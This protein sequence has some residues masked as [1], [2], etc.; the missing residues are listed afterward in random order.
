MLL[1]P[2]PMNPRVRRL[3]RFLWL[4]SLQRIQGLC[5]WYPHETL[6]GQMGILDKLL[7][8]GKKAAGDL[9]GDSSM[10][11]EGAAQERQ[12]AAEDRAAQHEQMAQ[13][14]RNQAAEAH[15]ERENT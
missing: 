6:E 13:E 9:T 11:R 8:R 7:G 14:Q 1:E 15:A 10:R 4:F 12:G 3:W 2:K 5:W